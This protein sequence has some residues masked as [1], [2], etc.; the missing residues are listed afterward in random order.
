[1]GDVI[2]DDVHPPTLEEQTP[3]FLS[4]FLEKGFT[5]LS[6]YGWYIVIFGSITYYL[7]ATKVKPMYERW[8]KSAEESA[9]SAKYHKDPALFQAR[10]EIMEA[11]RRR[12]QEELEVK[13][14]QYLEKQKE[15]AEANRLERIADWERHEK[16]LGYRSKMKPKESD[17]GNSSQNYNPLM[18][19]GGSSGYRPPKKSCCSG[20]GCG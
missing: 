3:E 8:K 13:A 18:G 9:Y 11:A 5:I 15:I 4:N 14:R 20:G 12:M 6:E 7:W 2:G 1:M 17:S 10:Q 16:G 19:S